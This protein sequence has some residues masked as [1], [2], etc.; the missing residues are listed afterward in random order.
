MDNSGLSIIS[1]KDLKDLITKKEEKEKNVKRLQRKAEWQKQNRIKVKDTL[2][3]LTEKSE[4]NAKALKFMTRDTPGRP[5][6]E[7]D[8]PQLFSTILDIVQASSS[9]DEKRRSETIRSVKTLDDLVSELKSLNFT[10][11]RNATYCRLL[12]R[13]GNTLEAKRHVKTVPVKLL[14]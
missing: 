9:A 14:R 10:L 4:E 13:R 3:K 12:P 5:R 8:Q 1:Q 2:K 6:I 7:T 11:S